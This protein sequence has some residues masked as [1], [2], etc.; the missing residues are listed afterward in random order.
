MALLLLASAHAPAEDSLKDHTTVYK[1]KNGMTV[2]TYRRPNAPVFCG[3]VGIA[4][5]SVDEP[6]GQTGIAH[7]FE[8]MAFKGS[9]VIGTKDYEAELPIMEKMDDLADEAVRE[10]A[11]VQPD[12]ARIAAIREEIR[13]LQQQQEQFIVKD[14][15]D[16]I[17][18]ENGGSG[19]NAFTASDMTAYHVNLPKNRLE[20]F[21]W[22]EADR[23]RNPALREFYSERD[24]VVEERRQR[25]DDDP[26]GSL[27]EAFVTTAF[28]AHPYGRPTIG[29][30]SDVRFLTRRMAKQFFRERY[31]PKS[32]TL[33]VAGDVDPAEVK[34]LA[35]RYFGDWDLPGRPQRWATKEPAF[36]GEKRVSVEFDA[37]PTMLIGWHKPTVPHPDEPALGVLSA[38]I[39]DG[40]T[41][42]GYRELVDGQR[43]ALNIS[44]GTAPGSR[45]DHLFTVRTSPRAPHS[46]QELEAAIYAII[47]DIKANGVT[48]REVQR[49]INQAELDNIASRQSNY[50]MAIALMASNVVYGDPL[51]LEEEME[52]Y[53]KVTPADVQ[54]VA[55]T[56]LIAE[57]R[58]VAWITRP[59]AA[60]ATT[61]TEAAQ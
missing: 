19:M 26:F 40:R 6:I 33:V 55:Q 38:I 4:A 51:A 50:G 28:S 16:A 42:R 52:K 8:H 25:T 44:A 11:K 41:S 22:L 35:D 61:T 27:Y 18:A 45:Y 32:T 1:M 49:A 13:A 12:E 59:A 20:L 53:R 48:E 17:L 58:T 7:M 14:E 43:I 34:A 3:V 54:R 10:L 46:V 24:V 30:D 21:F 56:Y 15:F 29:W 9:K 5:G 2:V 60:S 23:M 57:K 31:G 47:E 39:G 36:R 37:E